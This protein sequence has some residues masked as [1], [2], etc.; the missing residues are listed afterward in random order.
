MQRGCIHQPKEALAID[1]RIT[2]LFKQVVPQDDYLTFKTD[3]QAMR[4]KYD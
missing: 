3:C 4:G 1:F 2:D